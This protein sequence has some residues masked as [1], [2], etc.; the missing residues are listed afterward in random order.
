MPSYDGNGHA[1][2]V[3][4]PARA[5]IKDTATQKWPPGVAVNPDVARDA[6]KAGIVIMSQDDPK[7]LAMR[8]HT[9][10]PGIYSFQAPVTG[11]YGFVLRG[12]AGGRGGGGDTADYD[13]GQGAVVKLDAAIVKGTWID[14]L[15]GRCPLQWVRKGGGGGGGGTYLV[16]GGDI[17]AVAGGGGGGSYY[18]GSPM[19]LAAKTGGHAEI[20]PTGEPAEAT[21]SNGSAGSGGGYYESGRS[22]SDRSRGLAFVDTGNGGDND[23]SRGPG[24]PGGF[25][26]GG[27]GASSFPA[28]GG[29]GG[30]IGGRAARSDWDSGAES[31]GGTSYCHPDEALDPVLSLSGLTQVDGEVVIVL[32]VPAQLSHQAADFLAELE[33]ATITPDLLIRC[34]DAAELQAHCSIVSVRAPRMMDAA[35]EA[36][37]TVPFSSITMRHVLRWCYGDASPLT[38]EAECSDI[39]EPDREV[40]SRKYLDT[41]LTVTKVAVLFGLDSLFH[42]CRRV[43]EEKMM[44]EKKTGDC[45]IGF[46][47]Q[48]TIELELPAIKEIVARRL[49]RDHERIMKLADTVVQDLKS[50]TAI[51]LAMQ[52]GHSALAIKFI[53]EER[54][55]LLETLPQDRGI[56]AEMRDAGVQL[57][58][59]GC[60][61]DV[62]LKIGQE[63]FAVHKFVL[64]ARCKFFAKSLSVDMSERHAKEVS[65]TTEHIQAS[66]RAD[67]EALLHYIY[68]GSTERIDASNALFILSVVEYLGFSESAAAELDA[69]CTHVIRNGIDEENA[70][71][72]LAAASSFGH[73]EARDLAL[74]FAAEHR[75][76]AVNA[77]SVKVLER[78]ELEQLAVR[79]ASV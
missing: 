75:E 73:T 15:V 48:R 74:E 65:L 26:G 24:Q 11:Q 70:L 8:E 19:G 45:D 64:A 52:L 16:V 34:N 40:L 14:V 68:T 63:S 79:L 61:S 10:N 1:R 18:S 47:L 39:S 4:L 20:I 44:D 51:A 53:D 69:H 12:A 31:C 38:D 50:P 35:V 2:R 62:T 66:S 59:S 17:L 60:A 30:Y 46:L 77:G 25:G 36:A 33:A 41:C 29:G 76:G 57:F 78:A 21:T 28:G 22:G 13:G 37:I 3:T 55:R 54:Q 42:I 71:T 7:T 43:C 32:P 67:S 23:P 5:G 6:A 49:A 72:L 27:A 56:D 58:E 9:R